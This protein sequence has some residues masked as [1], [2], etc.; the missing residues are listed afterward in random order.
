M[1]SLREL[2]VRLVELVYASLRLLFSFAGLSAVRARTYIDTHRSRYMS[3]PAT[4]INSGQ[5]RKIND[6][7]GYPQRRIPSYSPTSLTREFAETLFDYGKDIG[8]EIDSSDLSY[9]LFTECNDGYFDSNSLA[10]DCD[11]LLKSR[12]IRDAHTPQYFGREY[13]LG[14]ASR[15][16]QYKLH[17]KKRNKYLLYYSQRGVCEGCSRKFAFDDMT[18]DHM[19]PIA[20]GGGDEFDNLQLMCGPCNEEKGDSWDSH[21]E[22]DSRKAK[23]TIPPS[24]AS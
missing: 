20:S 1:T 5:W 8:V 24:S 11:E 15:H 18:R 12:G 17:D 19:R 13:V 7:P 23:S 14:E 21:P 2:T 4:T 10:R 9:F 6:L 22:R 3:R 16:E